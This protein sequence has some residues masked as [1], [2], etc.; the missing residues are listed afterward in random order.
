M[1]T[2][3][4]DK[5]A[6]TQVQL[7]NIAAGGTETSGDDS[8]TADETALYLTPDDSLVI[9]SSAPTTSTA[10]YVGQFMLIPTA[11]SEALYICTAKGSTYTWKQVTLS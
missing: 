10:G 2:N 5:L 9:A 11:G 3:P 4:L 7:E 1:A 8:Y 6:L